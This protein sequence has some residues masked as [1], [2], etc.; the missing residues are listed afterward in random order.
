MLQRN[1]SLIDKIVLVDGLGGNGKT[2]FTS[3]L[4]SFAKIEKLNYSEEIEYVCGLYHLGEVSI[5]TAAV[6]IKNFAD[7]KLYHLMMSREINFRPSDLSS[8]FNY[9]D[10]KK[11]I[12]RLFN[13]GNETI[14]D[15]VEEEKP[16]LH[17]ATHHILPFSQP[18]ISAFGKKVL[19]LEILRHPAYMIKQGVLANMNTLIGDVRN[20]TL[21]FDYLGNEY[22]YYVSEWK[23]KFH[24]A[25]NT[26]RAI[27]WIENYFIA[28]RSF[29]KKYKQFMKTQLLFI[30]FEP[31]VLN[32]DKYLKK[33]LRF[34]GT[35]ETSFTNK[36]LEKQ[37]IPRPKVAAG[38]DLEIYRRCGWTDQIDGLSER[39]EIDLRK[40]WVEQR[41]NKRGFKVFLELCDEYE[42]KYWNPD[43]PLRISTTAIRFT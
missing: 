26:E 17:I 22:P 20:F 40:K 35:S 25:N 4:P 30:P 12:M 1:K 2:L 34:I 19:F 39:D 13:A 31:F 28:L 14:P 42:K 10:P 16:I 37:K 29:F 36:V 32:P 6:L 23:E 15:L 41:V 18:I 5:N 3:I 9:P 33:M 7:L 24:N 21:H 38:I 8:V 43:D 11:Y 27:Y